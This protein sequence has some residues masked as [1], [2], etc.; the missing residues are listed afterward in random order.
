MPAEENRATV[1]RVCE[2][3]LDNRNQAMLSETNP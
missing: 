3:A 2:Q 1:R